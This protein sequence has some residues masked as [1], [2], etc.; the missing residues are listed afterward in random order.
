MSLSSN[1]PYQTDQIRDIIS[2][3][4][5]HSSVDIGNH[6]Y[7]NVQNRILLKCSEHY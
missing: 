6:R 5:T 1:K 7:T 2:S 4:L 3:E